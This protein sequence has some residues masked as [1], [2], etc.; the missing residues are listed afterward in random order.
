MTRH[1][2]MAM[3]QWLSATASDAGLHVDGAR[4]AIDE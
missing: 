2:Q 4:V 3:G 1:S